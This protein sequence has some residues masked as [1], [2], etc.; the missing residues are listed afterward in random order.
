MD[1]VAGSG[2]ATITYQVDGGSSQTITGTSGN[3]TVPA[4]G[5]RIER[6][7][8]HYCLLRHRRCR[9]RRGAGEDRDGEDRRDEA[10]D[11][12]GDDPG[13][14]GR[15]ERLVPADERAVRPDRLRR[16]L[17]RGTEP[18]HR[19][20]RR[21]P[22][23]HGRGDGVG[24]GHAHDHLLVGRQRREHRGCQGG[25]IK[26]DN[27][28]PSTS[29]A[30]TPAAPNGSG[31]WYSTTPSFALSA[32][33]ATSGV[34]ST[35]YRIDSGATQTYSGAVSIPDGQHTITYWSEDN[36]GNTES[37]TTT[38]TIKVD[39]VKPSTSIT[40]SPASP[41]GTNGW[42]V[43]A[44]SFTLSGSDADLWRGVHLLQDRRG[45]N[46]DVHGERGLDTPGLPHRQLLVR[47]HRRQHRERDHERRD[48]GRPCQALDDADHRAGEPGRL[49]QLVPA[50][51]ASPSPWPRPTRR[52]A[53]RTAS[54]RSTAAASRPTQAP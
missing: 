21:H 12:A 23:L 2:V 44:T 22:D 37:A 39:T 5:R 52:P 18:L 9:E 46:P 54:T 34:A 48:Q 30:V 1:G 50:A 32:S 49:E 33:D 40:I 45:D 35:L 4:P 51:R 8:A 36:A 26:L 6:R 16:S 10:V 7:D 31:G 24:A 42:R 15:F 47:R 41:D 3:V 28:E 43:S 13:R 11:H 20:R 38:S 19:G 27:V 17:W 14:P 25:T 53:S 29:I